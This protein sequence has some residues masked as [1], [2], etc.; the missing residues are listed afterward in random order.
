MNKK[1]NNKNNTSGSINPRAYVLNIIVE[2]MENGAYSDKA[3]HDVLD[4]GVIK[5]KRD[6]AFI[7][8]LCEGVIERAITLDYIIEIGRAHV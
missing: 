7:S 2:I 1:S 5:D 4:S 3:L 8:R 6:R